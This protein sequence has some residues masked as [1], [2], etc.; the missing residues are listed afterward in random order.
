M[1]ENTPAIYGEQ[2]AGR[3]ATVRKVLSALASNVTEATFDIA[4]LLAEAK[5]TGY[6]RAWGYETLA[7]YAQKELHI[8][9]RKSQYLVRIVQV[10]KHLGVDRQHYEPVGVT[11]LREITR[12]NP[13]DF[14]YNPT[15]STNEPMRDHMV[16]LLADAPDMTAD[17]VEERVKELLGQTGEDEMVWMPAYPVKRAVRDKIILVAQELARRLLGSAGK[18]EEGMALEYS[19]GAVEEVVHADFIV[20]NQD[21]PIQSQEN[22]NGSADDAPDTPAL[23][24]P[25]A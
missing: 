4:E 13:E 1:N 17:A 24:F 11:K 10:C 15:T 21:A 2:V 9:Q 14:F 16:Q 23:Q 6:F 5:S 22:T 3:A 25:P 8:R 18:D 19:T 12:L 7:E 20:G